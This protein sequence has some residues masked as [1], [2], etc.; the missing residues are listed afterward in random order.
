LK[1]NSTGN[2]EWQKCLGGSGFDM[3]YSIIQTS[4]GGYAI[5]GST[6]SADGDV[7]GKHGATDAWVVHL[8]SSG[9]I[10]WQKCLGGTTGDQ[11][12]NS[13][14]QTPDGGY[15][16]A[17][18][19][20]SSDLDAS[21][22]HGSYDAWVVKLDGQGNTERHKCLGGSSSEQANS[23]VR[24]TDGGYAVA[25]ITASTD[26]DVSGNHGGGDGWIVR[27]DSSMN[28]LWQKSIGGTD[29]EAIYSIVQ[30]SDGGYVIAGRT[31]STDGDSAG[32]HGGYDMWIVALT[33]SGNINW[34]KCIG[35][36]GDEY[37]TSMIQTS[38]GYALAGY[39]TSSDG[40]VTA[41][42]GGADFFIV[43]LTK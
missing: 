34:Q 9:S 21:G 12:A 33:A 14:I 25:I 4:E 43:T 2:L 35:G 3:A 22:N 37:A 20:S 30:S 36:T 38:D 29:D 40:Q 5:A 31:K 23:I 19:T 15:A 8:N 1:L 32:N 24:T 10:E 39:S 7:S 42:H 17:G 16:V 13:I 26:G 11:M 18:R 27:L 6:N 41:N 28:I